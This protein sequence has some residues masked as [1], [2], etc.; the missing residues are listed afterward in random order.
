MSLARAL[1][2]RLLGARHDERGAVA[3]LVALSSLLMLSIAALAVDMGNAWTQR[4]EVQTQADLAALAGGALLPADTADEEL[5]IATE[6]LRYL[7]SNDTYGQDDGASASW[8]VAQLLDE[9]TG[10]APDLTDGQVLFPTPTSLTVVAPPSRVEFGFAGVMDGVGDSTDVQAEATV[11]IRS[12]GSV[13]PMFLMTGCSLGSQIIKD[14]NQNPEPSPLYDPTSSSNSAPSVSLSQ[15]EPIPE[16]TPITI[17]LEGDD[18]TDV[19]SVMFTRDDRN[20]T[21]DPTD[22]TAATTG[23]NKAPATL[24]VEVPPGVLSQPGVWFIRVYNGLTGEWTK[25]GSALPVTV[26]SGNTT[27][28]C[29]SASTGDFGILQSPRFDADSAAQALTDN[30][31]FGLDHSL[32]LWPTDPAMANGDCPSVPVGNTDPILDYDPPRDP[33]DGA[34]CINILN[35]NQVSKVT[36]GLIARLA[37]PTTSGCDRAGGSSY[38]N[39]AG[40]DLNNDVLTCYLPADTTV[41]QISQ[42][43][44][45]PEHVL[46]EAIFDSPRFFWVPMISGTVKP[47][48]GDYALVGYR[49]V[50]I[51]DESSFAYKGCGC[52]STRN[53]IVANTSQISLIQVVAFDAA[54]LPETV[55]NGSGPSIPYTGSGTRVISLI[56]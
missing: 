31:A 27:P 15:T 50:F 8:T 49:A 18:F 16:G 11:E 3:V 46:D 40:H 20:L 17:T 52:A 35:G 5:A 41:G 36:D 9:D 22:I 53:G 33:L 48:N 2:R 45:A 54:S 47:S 23:A 13:L 19:T 43:V 29:G 37:V 39:V 30:I 1:R 56:R 55:A 10:G 51:T 6:V 28:G 32:A 42:E 34:N 38:L 7:K 21:A 14:G 24:K 44:G 26:T 25:D 12:P 4:R